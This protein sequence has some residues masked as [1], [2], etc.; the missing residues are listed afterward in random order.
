[1]P[2]SI[3][4]DAPVTVVF[5]VLNKPE[6]NNLWNP[7]TETVT[8][9]SGKPN[10]CEVKSFMGDFTTKKAAVKNKSVTITVTDSPVLKELKYELAELS[11]NQTSVDGTIT[12]ISTA[13]YPTIHRV[14]GEKLIQNL[15]KFAEHIHASLKSDDFQKEI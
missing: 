5:D 2:L 9:I 11:D 15:K 4:I 8:P 14:V 7:V 10:E 6:N 12:L 1:M 3:I 13:N